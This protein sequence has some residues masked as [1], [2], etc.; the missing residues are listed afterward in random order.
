MSR[1]CQTFVIGDGIAREVITNDIQRYLGP[2]ALVRAGIGSGE[3]DGKM[4]YVVTAYRGLTPQMIQDLRLDTQRWEEEQSKG[5]ST[6]RLF[7]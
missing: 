2:D 5:G 1:Q 6:W 4:G 3:D 7:V